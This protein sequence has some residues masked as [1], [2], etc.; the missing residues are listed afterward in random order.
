MESYSIAAYQEIN[1]G[2]FAIIT[3]PFL[4]AVMF[5]DIGHGAIILSAA[6]FMIL[7]ERKLERKTLLSH[8][9]TSRSGR[10]IILL[11]GMF[12]IYTGLLYNDL[13]SKSLHL[14]HSGRTFPG[15]NGTAITAI[16]NGHRYPFGLDPGWHGADNGL[17]FTNSYEMK[18]S[19]I[20]G[21]IHMTFALCLQVPNHIRFKRPIDIYANF[22]PQ[23]IFL[24]SIFG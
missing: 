19:I 14:W 7:A 2:L 17:V 12:S 24:Q 8:S 5:G 3:F 6:I 23:V 15:G 13:F 4:F 22:I 21:V 9:F 10:Y 20:L 11:M 1:P 18:M 16:D